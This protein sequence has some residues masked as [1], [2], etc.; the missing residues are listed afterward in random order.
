MQRRSFLR[1]LGLSPA[2]IA[3]EAHAQGKFPSQQITI[4]V[5]YAPGG[6]VDAM[7]R[8]V[9]VFVSKMLGQPVV[10]ENRPG[11]AGIIGS[12]FVRRAEPSGYTLLCTANGSFTMAPRMLAKRPFEAADFAAVA[13]IGSTPMVL[14]TNAKGRFQTFA[15]MIEF[16]TSHP[17]EV[18]I[19]HPGNGTTNHVAILRLQEATGARFTIVPYKGS[20]PALSDLLGGQIDAM[21]DQLPSSLP[22]IKMQKLTA[23]AVTGENP[24]PDLPMVRPLAQLIHADFN[25]STVTGIL[26]P[27]YT[28]IEILDT[29]NG[30]VNAAL[31]DVETAT[32]LKDLGVVPTSGIARKFGDF[33]LAEDQMA[34]ALFRQGLLKSDS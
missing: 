10:I 34:E 23:L 31:V 12:D 25:V 17:D 33:L 22:H 18:T 32:R 7:A 1:A 20:A 4:V 8:L 9:G 30:A 27:A 3:W 14:A 21:V 24:A 6:N 28:P 13:A 11:A 5:P 16:A 2:A 29:L 19:A 26:A 15:Q